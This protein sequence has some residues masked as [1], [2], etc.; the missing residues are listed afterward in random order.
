MIGAGEIVG[1]L[2]AAALLAAGCGLSPLFLL[3]GAG[4]FVFLVFTV[5]ALGDAAQQVALIALD[6]GERGPPVTA[7]AT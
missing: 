4:C 5:A 3:A 6:G 1:P 2:I 7:C